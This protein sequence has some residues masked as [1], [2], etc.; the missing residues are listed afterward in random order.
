MTQSEADSTTST[1]K[2]YAKPA[3]GTASQVVPFEAP[4]T[5]TLHA[6]TAVKEYQDRTLEEPTV[7]KCPCLNADIS[8]PPAPSQIQRYRTTMIAPTKREQIPIVYPIKSPTKRATNKKLRAV[9]IKTPKE[10]NEGG[11]VCFRLARD[12]VEPCDA[13]LYYFVPFMIMFIASWTVV[14]FSPDFS[15]RYGLYFCNCRDDERAHARNY[16][17]PT[18]RLS[19]SHLI[20]CTHLTAKTRPTIQRAR[21]VGQRTDALPKRDLAGME[22]LAPPQQGRNGDGR[23]NKCLGHDN[24]A[25]ILSCSKTA[26]IAAVR[27]RRIS[28]PS[29]KLLIMDFIHDKRPS[30]AVEQILLLF[31]DV[32]IVQP[33][34]CRQI[35]FASFGTCLL[36]VA[37][38]AMQVA[39]E[40]LLL[41]F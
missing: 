27:F 36:H 11:E 1:S 7:Q 10:E 14:S 13:G 24:V 19:A 2:E 35:S 17:D 29:R 16:R 12:A 41:L 32:E 31:L 21:G 3:A 20:V 25:V 9:T 23:S 6:P 37:A 4:E 39:R 8:H 26:T 33:Y 22:E 5:T 18:E 15:A 28:C 40:T 38:T 34:L 30:S